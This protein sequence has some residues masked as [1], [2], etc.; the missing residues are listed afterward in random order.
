MCFILND[1]KRHESTTS[2]SRNH[3]WIL[4]TIEYHIKNFVG[5]WE[6]AFIALGGLW[7][8]PKLL[9]GLTLNIKVTTE[10]EKVGVHS[11]VHAGLS[12][13]GNLLIKSVS[14]VFH[15][16]RVPFFN[17]IKKKLYFSFESPWCISGSPN[18]VPLPFI[19]FLLD[20]WR[21]LS[22]LQSVPAK[23]ELARRPS[24][25][26]TPY[27]M[28]FPLQPVTQSLLKLLLS[29]ANFAYALVA[30]ALLK[31]RRRLGRSKDLHDSYSKQILFW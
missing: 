23:L 15:F 22:L 5:V 17:K 13:Y 8:T 31:N 29:V 2:S 26:N 25:R 3:L 4:I 9:D 19:A 10:G 28:D 7:H 14:S 27:N 16:R 18:D 1:L 24:R 12:I 21:P 11:L 30:K 20:R 6:L